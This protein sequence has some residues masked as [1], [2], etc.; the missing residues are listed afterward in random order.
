MEAP[1]N[2]PQPVQARL[3]LWDAVS[4]IIGIV[5][6]AGIYETPPLVFKNV[7]GPWAGL[8]VWAL[9]GLLCLCGALCYAELATTYPRSGGD[10]VY[11]TRAF[12]PWVGFLFG[13]A[14]LAVIITGS[15]GMMGYVFADYAVR[16]WDLGPGSTFIYAASA[17]AALSLLNALGVVFGKAAQN[18]L[19]AAKVLGL[20]GILAAGLFARHSGP[21][22][23]PDAAPGSTS[24]GF[25]F[26]LV[27]YTYGGWNDAAFVAAEQ[28]NRRRNIPLAL[29]LGTG[30]IALIYVAV[31]AAYLSTLG[32]E[33]ARQSR[34][35]AADAL[36]Q[37]LGES[38][39]RV[40]SA[41][42]MVSALGAI[43]GLIFT[44]S[45]VY[46]ALGAEHSVFGW[47]GRWHPRLGVPLWSLL[48]QAVISILLIAVVG[49][50]AG[51]TGVDRVLQG[52]GFGA[53]SWGGHGGFEALLD[54]TA[55]IFWL[56]F[57]G[58]GLSLFVLREKDR[59]AE[60]PFSVPLYPLVP[61]IFCNMCAY[62]LYSATTYAGQKTLVGV[63]PLLAGLPLY[64]ISRKVPN[65]D[66]GPQPEPNA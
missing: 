31:N 26:I 36:Q 16:L 45:R 66:A 5:I 47:L 48:A 32:F 4:I 12:G 43:N 49:T 9:A 13:W 59:W 21:W 19:S 23:A 28:T 44:G 25:A 63:A 24:L 10:Y 56:F 61:I 37:L 18:L 2:G 38:G 29:L 40:M 3:G 51:R 54:C 6:G 62:M 27:L 53:A 39:S 22:T 1:L 11:L 30:L 17:V 14:Q 46:S 8:G 50:P 58:T 55:P 34:A 35:V 52:L 7:S 20:G 65:G 33:G 60:R 15:I 57:L 64:W 41:L 42:V